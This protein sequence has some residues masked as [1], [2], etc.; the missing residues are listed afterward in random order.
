MKPRTPAQLD[1]S[2]PHAEAIAALRQGA[3]ANR[4]LALGP[5]TPLQDSYWANWTT[6]RAAADWLSI[7]KAP[8]ELPPLQWGWILLALG[9]IAVLIWCLV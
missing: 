6:L 3:E 2:S 7:P 9:L 5:P 4:R 8:A 1:A